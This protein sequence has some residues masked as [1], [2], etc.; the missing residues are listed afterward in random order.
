MSCLD[1]D[2]DPTKFKVLQERS[3]GYLF[4]TIPKNGYY[5]WSEAAKYL[6][7]FVNIDE[8]K[9]LKVNNLEYSFKFVNN[10]DFDNYVRME[11]L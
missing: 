3:Y 10:Q 6:K 2:N 9:Y 5:S 1:L 7:Q 4:L 8:I 11:L